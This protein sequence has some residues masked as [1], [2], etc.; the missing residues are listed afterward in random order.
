MRCDET[1]NLTIM[2]QLLLPLP[3]SRAA[4][5]MCLLHD[6]H[7][8]PPKHDK[9]RTIDQPHDRSSLH[10]MTPTRSR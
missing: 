8:L 2:L 6:T 3:Q 7:T 4:S 9:K 10:P 5:F 1:R